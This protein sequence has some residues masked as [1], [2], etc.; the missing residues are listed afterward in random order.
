MLNEE[1]NCSAFS[2]RFAKFINSK[3][4]DSRFEPNLCYHPLATDYLKIS[5]LNPNY[6]RRNL[7]DS[8]KILYEEESYYLVNVQTRTQFLTSDGG[9]DSSKNLHFN[10]IRDD[11]LMRIARLLYRY[12]LNLDNLFPVNPDRYFEAEKV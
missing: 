2:Q 12:R 8:R 7:V 1:F 6:V 10:Q 9:S 3:N 5:N 4:L 11:K